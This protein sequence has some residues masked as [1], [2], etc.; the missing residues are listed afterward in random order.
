M[1][2][3]KCIIKIKS[4]IPGIRGNLIYIL[5]QLYQVTRVD[6]A[7]IGKIVFKDIGSKTFPER[8]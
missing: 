7:F 2:N 4:N 6:I 5:W 8:D 1:M 3:S